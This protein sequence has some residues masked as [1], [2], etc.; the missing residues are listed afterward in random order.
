[1]VGEEWSGNPV[2]VSHWLRGVKNR[3][4]YVSYM[5]S[6]M[7][8]P[9]HYVLRRALVDHDS[10]H[11]GLTDLYEALVNDTLYPEPSNM[12]LFEGNHD[13]PR[14]YSVLNEDLDLWK[15]A[16]AY[17][18]TMPRTPQLYYGT[19]VLMTSPKE[20]D[21]GATRRD[22]PGGWAGD[23]VNAFTGEGLSPAQREAQAF[24]R[25]LMRWRQT[26]PVIHHG[27]LTHFWPQGGTYAWVRHD[28]KSAVLVVINKNG[29]AKTLPTAR[30]REA[31]GDRRQGR[32][33][34]TGQV[35]DL[36]TSVTVPARSVLV[37]DLE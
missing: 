13:V 2:V 9:L 1:M 21:D 17:V 4:G 11:S 37:M 27:A 31:I 25:T 26:R 6:M 22:F 32:D 24:L 10:L 16:I 8:F 12:V 36:S 18:L 14:L 3:D 19:E 29:E 33:V 30:F 5:P 20:R 23:K 15:M 35:Q 7:D 28:A 34:V